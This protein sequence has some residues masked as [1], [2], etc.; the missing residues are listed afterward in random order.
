MPQARR[1]PLN[2]YHARRIQRCSTTRS[3]G[4]M[5]PRRR[6]RPVRRAGPPRPPAASPPRARRPAGARSRS[7]LRG[8]DR[9]AGGRAARRAGAPSCAVRDHERRNA[10]RKTVLGGRA[11]ATVDGCPTT[12]SRSPLARRRTRAHDRLA[13]P[14]RQRRRAARR[15]RRLRRR[16]GARRPRPRGRRQGQ[17]R[18]R[19]GARVEVL[20]PSPDRIAPAAD[21]PGA[22]WQVLPYERQLEVKAEQVREA[23]ERIG[24]LTTSSSSRS[25]RGRAVALPQQARVLVRHGATAASSC[26]A[27]TLPAA[28]TRSCRWTTACWPPSARTPCASRCWR[29]R[30][31][32]DWRLGPARAARPAAQPRGP[33]GPP[34][35]RAAGAARHLARRDRH[36]LADRRGPVRRPVL[37]PPGA[38]RRD[39]DGRRDRAALRHAAAASGS[40]GS[41]SSISPEAFFQTNTEMAEQLYGVAAEF[42]QL[43][44]H[45]RVFDLY[46]GIG[47][48]GLTLA[49][50][51]REVVGVEI[52]EAGGRRRDRERP[53]QRRPQRALLRRRHPARHARSRRAGRAAGRRR[54]RPAARRPLAEGRAPHPRGRSPRGSSTSP[55]TRPRWR[56]TRRRWSRPATGSSASVPVDMFPQTPHI[57]SVALL[58]RG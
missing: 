40:A 24:K 58:E 43:R 25:S 29:G 23:L 51:A 9:R 42:A 17:A 56:R 41:T 54:R 20:E 31:P 50:R 11:Q 12:A 21:H 45:E 2:P 4:R 37:D 55:A 35:R 26:S 44:G 57:E 49:A 7:T 6:Q 32:R 15:L 13:R 8:P 46:C 39:H 16:S 27:S 33:R 3:R 30:A 38:D 22:P 47:T 14:R 36:R 5:T 48:I 10:N 19:R 1:N 34:H 53:H 18:L 28:G 52:V